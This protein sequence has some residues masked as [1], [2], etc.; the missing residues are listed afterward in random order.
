MHWLKFAYRGAYRV[1][2]P[3]QASNQP[4]LLVHPQEEPLDRS[5]QCTRRFYRRERDK[6]H[7]LRE[8]GRRPRGGAAGAGAGGGADRGAPLGAELCDRL[9]FGPRPGR[10]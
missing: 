4:A 9:L 6:R 5:C 2:S 10:Q 8:G 7:R 3:P 1:L